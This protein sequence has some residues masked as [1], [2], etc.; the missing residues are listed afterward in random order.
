MATAEKYT[1]L[2]FREKMGQ[3]GS[4]HAQKRR[5]SEAEISGSQKKKRTNSGQ[6]EEGTTS[7]LVSENTKSSAKPK[8]QARVS[9]IM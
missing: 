7:K 2:K 4:S 3:F 1:H 8:K 5:L 9:Y 6:P